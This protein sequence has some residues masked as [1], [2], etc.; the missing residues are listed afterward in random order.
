MSEGAWK[1]S[2]RERCNNAIDPYRT[3]DWNAAGW[4]ASQGYDTPQLCAGTGA[5]A[6]CSA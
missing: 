1:E 6:C 5:T 2:T 3:M 4:H